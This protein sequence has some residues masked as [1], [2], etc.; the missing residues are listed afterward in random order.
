MDRQDS[1]IS[2]QREDMSSQNSLLESSEKN[3]KMTAEEVRKKIDNLK[4][5]KTDPSSSS[6][7]EISV[8]PSF[9]IVPK[10][11]APPTHEVQLLENYVAKLSN[12]LPEFVSVTHLPIQRIFTVTDM[13]RR[14]KGEDNAP[15]SGVHVYLD[16]EIRTNLPG[17]YF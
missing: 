14:F 6:A 8:P 12:L 11:F 9:D 4:L 17:E 13:V 15:Y 3:L 10:T 16:G 1:E 7:V 2:T 5:V